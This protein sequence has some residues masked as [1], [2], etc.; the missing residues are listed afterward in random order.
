MPDSGSRIVSTIPPRRV[1][2]VEDDAILAM[3]IEDTLREA[4]SADIVTCSTTQQALVALRAERP[5]AI[6]LDVHLADSD[7]GWAIAELVGE[8]SPRPPRIVFS[9]GSPQDIPAHIAAMGVVL[10][11]PYDASELVAAIGKPRRSGLLGRLKN[12]LG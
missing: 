5:D 11:K 7:D 4:G 1:L 6:V 9:T 2:V 10:T 3:M 8:V 12:A